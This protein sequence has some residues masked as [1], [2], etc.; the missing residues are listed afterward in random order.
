MKKYLFAD[1]FKSMWR[2]FVVSDNEKSEFFYFHSPVM[3][4]RYLFLQKKRLGIAIS[5]QAVEFLSQQ[6]KEFKAQKAAEESEAPSEV[7]AAEKTEVAV[8][9][10]P[11][12]E[13]TAEVPAKE[14]GLRKQKKEVAA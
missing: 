11:E 1:S 2:V 7:A 14:S 4:M 5:R 9:S 12:M 13:L 8:D 10:A 6:C 3:A